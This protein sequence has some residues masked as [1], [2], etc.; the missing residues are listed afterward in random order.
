MKK[1]VVIGA[2]LAALAIAVWLVRSQPAGDASH[3]EV[4]PASFSFTP[5]SRCPRISRPCQ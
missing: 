5:T 4:I 1:L 3:R 2:S